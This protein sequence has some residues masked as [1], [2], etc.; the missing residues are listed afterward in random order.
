MLDVN[1]RRIV[2]KAAGTYFVVRDNS[3]VAEIEAENKMRLMFINVDQGPINMA[4]SFAKGDKTGFKSVFGSGTRLMRKRGNF[5]IDTCLDALNAGPITVVNLRSFDDSK[6]KAA[7]CGMNLNNTKLL[8]QIETTP[9]R[10]LFNVNSFWTPVYDNMNNIVEKSV[11]NFANVGRNDFSIFVVRSK[12]VA[13]ITSEGDESLTSCS[14]EIDEYPALNFNQKVKDTI[15]DVYLFNNTFDAQTSTTNKYFGHLFDDK[16]NIN[17]GRLNELIDIP[18]AGFVRMFTGSLIPNL[19]N[20]QGEEISINTVINQHF[21]ET[22]LICDINEDLFEM[23]NKNFFDPTAYSF[24]DEN[25]TLKADVNKTLLSH[26]L[27]EAAL[28]KKTIEHLPTTNDELKAPELGQLYE[29]TIEPVSGD[30]ASFIT[31]FE[32]GIR[33]GDTIRGIDRNVTVIKMEVLENNVDKTVTFNGYTKVKVTCNGVIK[34]DGTKIIKVEDFV[35]TSSIQPFA[36]SACKVRADQFIDGTEKRQNEILDMMINP[37]IVKGIR[38]LRGIRYVVDCFKSFVS[39]GYKYQY[40]SLMESLDD[41]NR[42]VRAIINEPFITDMQKSTN[43]C[44]KQT[45]NGTFDISYLATGGN[46]NLS[47]N[48]LTKFVDGADKCFFF[49]PGEMV[50][51]IIV[52]VA[53]KVSNLF[54]RKANAFDVVANETGILSGIKALEY[55]F[56]D[57]DRAFCEKFGW[58]PVIFFNGSYMIYG[59]RTGQ[60]KQTAQQQIHNSD[61]LAYIKESLYNLAKS[62]AF[63]KGNYDDYLRTETETK[64]FMNSLVLAGAIDANPKV[65]CDASNNTLE[66]RKQKIKLVHIEYTPVDCLEKVVFD[67]SIN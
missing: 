44:F 25:D 46:Q 31:A 33:Y 64:E 15:V 14:M 8:K 57:E 9:Y 7:V 17:Y 52:G 20:Q 2:P 29:Y 51:N 36:L 28:T 40:G 23:E 58:N 16:G 41:T 50:N 26:V 38:G 63:K 62:E 65:V 53:G 19:K 66:I 34:F 55:S 49:G 45:P 27:P 24:F 59:N 4:V 56:D 18:E 43:P 54:Y 35:M 22:G 32:Q 6:D 48:L 39:G 10:N 12:N 60:K 67:L 21:M 61:L 13:S 47:T 11:L 37:G 30:S 3:Q 42:F 1:L 5:S